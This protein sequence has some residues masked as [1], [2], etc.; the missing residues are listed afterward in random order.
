MGCIWPTPI[1]SFAHLPCSELLWDSALNCLLRQS[2]RFPRGILMANSLPATSLLTEPAHRDV[3]ARLLLL[4]GEH[5]RLPNRQDFMYQAIQAR[6]WKAFYRM[7]AS[8]EMASF[9]PCG[10]TF[11]PF[12]VTL[13]QTFACPTES[14]GLMSPVALPPVPGSPR[15]PSP[16]LAP[17]QDPATELL[18]GLSLGLH[19]E[20]KLFPGQNFWRSTQT[21]TPQPIHGEPCSLLLPSVR[22]SCG[23]F[24]CW[25]GLLWRGA[26]ALEGL[27]EVIR[28]G[29][30]L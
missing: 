27:W 23:Q 5:S 17:L 18:Y 4:Q 10:K 12:G 13:C 25:L 14:R 6:P 9:I 20:A 15:L 16:S 30:K 22:S 1:S 21:R 11:V 26:E 2:V 3:W 28:D 19:S 7:A 24:N 8:L 29:R